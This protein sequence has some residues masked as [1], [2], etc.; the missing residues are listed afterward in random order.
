MA[1]APPP[2]SM[3]VPTVLVWLLLHL[4][5]AAATTTA[6]AAADLRRTAA[7]GARGRAGAGRPP[8]EDEGKGRCAA[9]PHG[10]GAG[11]GCANTHSSCGSWALHGE[12]RSNPKYARPPPPCTVLP[13][14]C[15]ARTLH[16]FHKGTSFCAN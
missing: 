9:T 7:S 12:C 16:S 11:G 3:A 6:A 1:R 10:H 14:R 15:I 4:A 2:W 8:K 13:P 5:A